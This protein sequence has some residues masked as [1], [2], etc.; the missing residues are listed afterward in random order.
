[1]TGCISMKI[2]S[3][4]S[5]RSVRRRVMDQGTRTDQQRWEIESCLDEGAE[6]M[7]KIVQKKELHQ[8]SAEQHN[9][10]RNQRTQSA[11]TINRCNQDI[12]STAQWFLVGRSLRSIPHYQRA[13]WCVERHFPL[14]FGSQLSRT[15]AMGSGVCQAQNRQIRGRGMEA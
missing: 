1:M 14:R 9:K 10:E 4:G 7:V 2:N 11:N 13:S 12:K 6:C 8:R 5:V 3:A 15:K